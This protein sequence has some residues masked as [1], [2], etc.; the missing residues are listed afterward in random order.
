MAGLLAHPV[1]TAFPSIILNSGNV[2][3]KTCCWAYSCGDSS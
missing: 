3:I 1:L 2:D